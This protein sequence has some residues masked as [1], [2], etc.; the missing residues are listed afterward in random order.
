MSLDFS[1]DNED[2]VPVERRSRDA[3]FTRID[4]Q[5][6]EVSLERWYELNPGRQPVYVYVDG[7]DTLVYS[8]NV[9]HNLVPMAKAANLYTSLCGPLENSWIRAEDIIDNLETGLKL[10]EAEPNHFKQFDPPNKWGN[11]DGFIKFVRDTLE[12][13]R[14]YPEAKIRIWK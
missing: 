14:S 3:I 12:A 11:Y 5:T 2:S 7:E 1:L 10:L 9:T 13:C 8:N 6:V 4:G